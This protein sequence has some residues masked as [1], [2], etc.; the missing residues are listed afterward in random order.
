[1]NNIKMSYYN[2]ID[3]SEETDVAS[4]SESKECDTCHYWYFL[5]K[6]F[7]FQQNVCNGCNDLLMMSMNLNDIAILNIKI[8]DYHCIISG[9]GKSKSK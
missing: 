2:R 1:M 3:V 8:V 7:Q 4:T 9:I 6:G 5:D